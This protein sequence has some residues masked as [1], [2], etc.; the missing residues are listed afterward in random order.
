MSAGFVWIS[1]HLEADDLMLLLFGERME[2]E[3]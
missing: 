1:S 3:F 2:L